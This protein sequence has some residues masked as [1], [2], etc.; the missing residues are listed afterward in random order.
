MTTSARR[1]LE[2]HVFDP[3]RSQ[4]SSLAVAVDRRAITSEPA[5]GSAMANPPIESALTSLGMYFRLSA[6]D[7]YRRIGN[8]NP[9]ACMLFWPRGELGAGPISSDKIR[10][11]SQ[12]ILFPPYSSGITVPK[13]PSC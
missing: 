5:V 12:P 7:P 6:S 2:I 3:F 4:W 10:V 1:A 8:A 13:K 9:T 11:E